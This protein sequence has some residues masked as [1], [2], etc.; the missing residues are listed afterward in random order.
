MK[1]S[2]T[3]SGL[4]KLTHYW[5]FLLFAGLTLWSVYVML[6]I[7]NIAKPERVFYIF[8]FCAPVSIIFYVIQKRRLKYTVVTTTLTPAE[9]DAVL[10][11]LEAGKGWKR[12]RKTPFI[13]IATTYGGLL[14]GSWGERITIEQSGGMVYMN[15]ICD[16]AKP[17][18]VTSWGRNKKNVTAFKHQIALQEKK[19]QPLV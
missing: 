4:E 7:T 13:Y 10:L 6:V 1:K 11:K 18:S 12:K 17:S 14:S 3:L 8:Y 2:V 5:P 15:S 19:K 16:P 9:I